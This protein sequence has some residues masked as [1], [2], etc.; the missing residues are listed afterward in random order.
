VE[1]V[2][3]DEHERYR[4][5]TE[6]W[7]RVYRDVVSISGPDLPPLFTPPGAARGPLDR[8]PARLSTVGHTG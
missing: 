8:S 4:A 7:H 1:R 5:V 6:R 2:D 3:P